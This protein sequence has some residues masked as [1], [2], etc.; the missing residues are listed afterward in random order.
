MTSPPP[1]CVDLGSG[2]ES[3]HCVAKRTFKGTAIGYKSKCELYT[4]STTCVFV[5]VSLR[6]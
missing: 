1:L 6:L 5:C 4:V 3:V 2:E